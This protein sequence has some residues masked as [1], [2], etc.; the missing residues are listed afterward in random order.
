MWLFGAFNY[1][2][3]DS[4]RGVKDFV[5]ELNPC[6]AVLG[7]VVEEVSADDSD[8]FC[9]ICGVVALKCNGTIAGLWGLTFPGLFL[10]GYSD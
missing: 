2:W 5:Q 8:G 1:G 3:C 9:C 4:Y 6:C 10:D 7:E